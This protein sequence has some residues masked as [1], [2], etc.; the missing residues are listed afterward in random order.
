MNAVPDNL[1][2]DPG[3]DSRAAKLG[4]FMDPTQ[5]D[6]VANALLLVARELWVMKDRQR[7]LEALLADAGIVAPGAV[8]AHQPGEALA[9]DLET[10][11]RAF[12]KSLMAVLCP[13][14]AA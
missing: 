11:R 9:K 2:N 7:V 1:L 3:A 13:E 10:E 5:V 14:T 4:S 8:A 6:D 12:A